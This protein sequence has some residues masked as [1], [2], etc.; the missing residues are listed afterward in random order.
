MSPDPQM[1]YQDTAQE[2]APDAPMEFVSGPAPARR[3]GMSL[4]VE[5]V[6]PKTCTYD[7]IYCRLGPTRHKTV[8]RR[9]FFAPRDI[10]EAVAARLHDNA[11]PEFITLSG[12]GEPTLHSG[13]GDIIAGI[14]DLTHVPVAVLTS[15]ALFHDPGVR[16]AVADADLI[17]PS[18]DAPDQQLFS[19]INR[20]HPD[21]S[22][23]RMVAGLHALRREFR[24]IIWLEVFLI[25]QVTSSREC[26]GL[27]AELA[28]SMEPDKIQLNTVANP[29]EHACAMRVPPGRLQALAALFGDNT[30]IIADI[31]G[32][33][34][35][36]DPAARR[37]DVLALL[38]RG[39]HSLA[40]VAGALSMH[41]S[42]TAAHLTQLLHAGII[43]A[44][45]SES[46]TLY[47]VK[48]NP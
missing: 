5:L 39:P 9:N 26:A 16:R 23:E 17:L 47:R 22:F 3:M 35:C 7:C 41:S 45:P 27:L 40:G 43:C 21:L 34:G 1:P 28:R 24:G 36:P 33:H 48:R 8:E 14:K 10:V 37:A 12:L 2:P 42:E 38:F 11:L 6:P 30:E 15:G 32:T 44:E 4:N 31:H 29:A 19:Q 13:I 25:N 18:L 46:G 20:P